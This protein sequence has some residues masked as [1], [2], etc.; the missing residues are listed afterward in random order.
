MINLPYTTEAS[1][2]FK[3]REGYDV[4]TLNAIGIVER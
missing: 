2:I 4:P 3:Y 1:I